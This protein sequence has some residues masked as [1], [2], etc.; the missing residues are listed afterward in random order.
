[1]RNY[2][3]I[4]PWF[5]VFLLA[6]CSLSLIITGENAI[7]ANGSP[8]LEKSWETQQDLVKP[9]SVIHDVTN[10]ILYVSNISGD[11]S[12]KDGDGFI[13]KITLNG[14]IEI[15]KWVEGLNAPKGLAISQEKLYVSDIDQVVKIDINT[16][17]VEKTY[18]APGAIFL[19]DVAA[20][21]NGNVY[22]SV[23]SMIAPSPDW[24]VGVSSLDLCQNGSWADEQEVTLYGY[25]AGTD[26]GITYTS[27]NEVTNPPDVIK[28]IMNTSFLVDGILV[29][30]GIFS[31]IMEN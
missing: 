11:T 19:N 9:E 17:T 16:G 31:F 27:S 12:T 7:G 21:T 10:N 20:D 26:S 29:P 6:F 30:V 1:M 3:Y 23:T 22:V 2:K 14:T 28:K 24:F 18:N 5:S 8:S 15:L 4:R 13:S 25:D